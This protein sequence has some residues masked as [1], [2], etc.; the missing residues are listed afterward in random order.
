MPSSTCP[1][2]RTFP[3]SP[4]DAIRPAAIRPAAIRPAARLGH[5]QIWAPALDS[6]NAALLRVAAYRHTHGL[7]LRCGTQTKGKGRWGR[8]FVSLP[9]EQLFVSWVWHSALGAANLSLVPLA[10]GIAVAQT[11]RQHL[12]L[13][14]TLKWPNDVC[15][16]RRKVAGILVESPNLANPLLTKQGRTTLII[17]VGLNCHGNAEQ[18]LDHLSKHDLASKDLASKDLASRVTT[19][20]QA[21]RSQ[22]LRSQTLRTGSRVDP[23]VDVDALLA[24]LLERAEAVLQDLEAGRTETLLA[25]WK[26]YGA[27]QGRIVRFNDPHGNAS[28]PLHGP[29]SSSSVRGRVLDLAPD[30][31]LIIHRLDNGKR[32]IHRGGTLDWLDD[33]PTSPSADLPSPVE[34][35][36]G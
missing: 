33:T 10:I 27:C 34:A 18:L 36:L 15:L 13:P 28:S 12:S 30:G 2:A 3:P 24:L 9:G 17:G 23:R 11:I 5:V 4:Q 16:A 7:V 22:A 25:Q 6:T 35:R 26:R 29:A 8:R 21:L 20:S 14:A 32:Y 19:L 31:A 1:P